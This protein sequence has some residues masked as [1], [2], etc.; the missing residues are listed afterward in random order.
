MVSFSC[1][2]VTFQ[3]L[4]EKC[5]DVTNNDCRAETQATIVWAKTQVLTLTGCGTF[6]KFFHL[7]VQFIC[8]GG[9]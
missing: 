6:G 9:K 5:D 2:S 3:K 7:F 8:G 4:H 1:C